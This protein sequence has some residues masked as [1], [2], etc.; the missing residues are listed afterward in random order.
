MLIAD[1]CAQ[2]LSPVFLLK[3]MDWAYFRG[4]YSH[5][6]CRLETA[7]INRTNRHAA[8]NV[9]DG[10]SGLVDVNQKRSDR[11]RVTARKLVLL[12]V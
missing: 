9:I 4:P 1:D 5:N 8:E 6:W 12:D 11:R 10:G 7:C 2:S 3:T